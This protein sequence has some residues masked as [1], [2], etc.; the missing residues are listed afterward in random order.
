MVGRGTNNSFFDSVGPKDYYQKRGTP[1]D[2]EPL[3]GRK[4]R[5]VVKVI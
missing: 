2:R 1:V 4:S 5:V 3:V